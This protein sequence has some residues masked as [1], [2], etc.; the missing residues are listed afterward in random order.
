MQLTPDN[1]ACNPPVTYWTET[2]HSCE[3]VTGDGT[4]R[5]MD[6]EMPEPSCWFENKK[7]RVERS[8]VSTGGASGQR[9]LC[10]PMA[11]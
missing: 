9:Q 6:D 1:V 7:L 5:C 3:G 11:E 2:L 10:V 4:C 8:A